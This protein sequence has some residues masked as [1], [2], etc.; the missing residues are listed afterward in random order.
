LKGRGKTLVCGHEQRLQKK[1]ALL[2]EKET[3]FW[4][5]MQESA[6][7]TNSYAIATR[8]HNGTCGARDAS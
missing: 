5:R 6:Q 8:K 2:K 7:S 1:S 3:N 4:T